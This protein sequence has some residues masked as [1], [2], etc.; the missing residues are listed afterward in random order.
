MN[1]KMRYLIKYCISLTLCMVF[2]FEIMPYAAVAEGSGGGKVVVSLGDSYSSGE[3]ITPF[4]GTRSAFKDGKSEQDQNWLAHRSQKSWAG[5]LR[6][7]GMPNDKTLKDYKRDLNKVGM[8]NYDEGF[9]WFFFASSGA[10][11]K[12]VIKSDQTV[13]HNVGGSTSEASIYKQ[14]DS[15]KAVAEQTEIDFVTITIGGNDVGFANI[16]T[17]AAKGTEGSVSS[18]V[19]NSFLPISALHGLLAPNF[20]QNKINKS[21]DTFNTKTKDELNKTYDAILDATSNNADIIVVG[22]PTLLNPLGVPIIFSYQDAVIINKAVVNFNSAIKKLVNGKNDPKLHFVDVQDAFKDHEAYTFDPYINS[23]IIPS[24]TEDINTDSIISCYSIHPND[25]GAAAYAKC[26]QAEINKYDK[27]YTPPATTAATTAATS[28]NSS[29]TPNSANNDNVSKA[30]EA[31]R[32]LVAEKNATRENKSDSYAI[33][34]YTTDSYDGGGGFSLIPIDNDNI[35]EL[36]IWYDTAHPREANLY[37]YYNSKVVSLG[38]YGGF[39]SFS[40]GPYSGLFKSE[41]CYQGDVSFKVFKLERGAV[42]EVINGGDNEAGAY[43]EIGHPV[44]DINGSSVS[45]DYYHE[46]T[47]K[48]DF[49]DY[50]YNTTKEFIGYAKL[51]GTE[52]K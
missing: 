32:Q 35:P 20:L 34:R 52:K 36:V 27:A 23:I 1:N 10:K 50:S 30:I 41:I 11:T 24:R 44:F 21:W 5:R 7:S 43:H 22:Y 2:V 15:L 14:L 49:K 37:T 28:A 40:Y 29:N 48:Y 46:V 13:T 39:G 3:G 4:Y 47:S 25:K 42:T 51:I 8:Y 6:L 16:M 17:Y 33:N 31:Y 38:T 19:V 26:V 12:D 9:H 18:L 45:A